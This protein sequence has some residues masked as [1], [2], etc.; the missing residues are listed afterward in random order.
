[1]RYFESFTDKG[2]LQINDVYLNLYLSRKI[3]IW[4]GENTI[5]FNSGEFIAAIGN[6]TRS[7]DGTIVNSGSSCFYKLNSSQTQAYVYIFCGSPVESSKSGLQIFNKDGKLI[8]DSNTKQ[9]RVLASGGI[10]ATAGDAK[11][12]AIACGGFTYTKDGIYSSTVWQDK[13]SRI[14]Y[15]YEL[16]NKWVD[17][18][19]KELEPVRKTREVP[20]EY[21]WTMPE[22]VGHWERDPFT[23]LQNWVTEVKNVQHCETRYKT[24]YYT[25]YEWVTHTRN[26]L[27]SVWENVPHTVFDIYDNQQIRYYTVEK[28]FN[29]CLINGVASNFLYKTNT[30]GEKVESYRWYDGKEDFLPFPFTNF[31]N[32]QMESSTGTI[33]A[34]SCVIL[35]VTGL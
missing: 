11:S 3:P 28:A 8:F 22:M 16:V 24:E 19:Y 18:E 25:D 12:L 5:N 9:A 20:Y 15:R 30:S 23:G 34:Y 35:D 21:C 29:I 6:G 1:M 4:P 2:N 17:E 27:K 32:Q 13:V 26:V 10:G 31:Y 14:E 7:I 33:D